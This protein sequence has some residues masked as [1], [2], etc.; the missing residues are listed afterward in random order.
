MAVDVKRIGRAVEDHSHFLRTLTFALE[1]VIV[2]QQYMIE[3]LLV[4]LLTGGH[5]LLEGVPG[6]A[7]TLTVTTLAQAIHAQF[8]RIQFTPDLL[9]AD[10][11]GTLIYNPRDGSFTPKQGPIF[12]HIVLADEIN[13]APPKVQ[14]A[15]LEAMQEK[16]VTLGD[17]S[18][19]L[20]EPFLVLA[21]QNPIE[22]EGTYPLPEAQVDRFMLKLKVTYPSKQEERRIL[23]RMAS[24]RPNT[25]VQPVVQ[26]EDIM[27]ARM[28]V[29]EVYVDDKIKDYVVDI[30]QAT[31][32]PGEYRLDLAHLIEYGASPR[33]TI[34]LTLGAK[35]YAFLQ[36]R[37]Y[38]TPQDVKTIGPDVLR[39]RLIPSYEA[40]AE[41]HTSDDLVKR[42]LDHVPV[43]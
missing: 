24:T 22:Q 11:I 38:V 7:K 8:Q 16:Q 20:A 42:I 39:H 28:V 32:S 41:E 40:E 4:G 5:V 37:G 2:G 18:Y 27:Q 19:A 10:L 33:A 9:P 25:D 14:S 35:A 6:L 13:R 12:A 15:L 43:P 3:R 30:V 23:D 34:A 21:T 31:R 36:G 1:E 26:P 29:D 17:E